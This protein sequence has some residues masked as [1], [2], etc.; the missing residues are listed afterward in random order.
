MARGDIAVGWDL[1]SIVPV[2]VE[3]AEAKRLLCKHAGD[4]RF[5]KSI[6]SWFT[7]ADRNLFRGDANQSLRNVLSGSFADLLPTLADDG[8][9]IIILVS[10]IKLA[11]AE[12][13]HAQLLRPNPC[14]SENQL[15]T[16]QSTGRA[17]KANALRGCLAL[18]PILT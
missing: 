11:R 2:E 18:D 3:F 10:A 4:A 8:M 12:K 17:A 9:S 14:R 13:S 15:P 16:V 7:S 6:K 5:D 1:K